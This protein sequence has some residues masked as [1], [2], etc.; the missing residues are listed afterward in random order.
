MVEYHA[1]CDELSTA[2]CDSELCVCLAVD[3]GTMIADVMHPDLV[4]LQPCCGIED[5]M[6]TVEAPPLRIGTGYFCILVLSV[7]VYWHY[8]NPLLMTWLDV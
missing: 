8:C 1:G 7:S 5:S 3:L 6:D 4:S 2:L